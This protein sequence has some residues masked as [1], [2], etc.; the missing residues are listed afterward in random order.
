M[1]IHVGSGVPLFPGFGSPARS[2]D[3]RTEVR[4]RRRRDRQSG[5]T[6]F[7]VS[8]QRAGP[9]FDRARSWGWKI[10]SHSGFQGAPPRIPR[11]LWS[12][13]S[14]Q[15]DTR[16]S[17]TEAPAAVS[18]LEGSRAYGGRGAG[19]PI[20]YLKRRP[21]VSVE[22]L[23]RFNRTCHCLI[24]I[25]PSV[26]LRRSIVVSRES[27]YFGSSVFAQSRRFPA[28]DRLLAFAPLDRSTFSS[29]DRDVLGAL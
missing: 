21:C 18:F 3:A 22:T 24:F 7:D 4:L 5:R 23:Q 11:P 29:R 12:I 20:P 10:A 6:S 9:R 14:N 16:F 2:M 15:Q 28:E 13:S 17:S 26:A 8:T 27:N 25:V 1:Q 19:T